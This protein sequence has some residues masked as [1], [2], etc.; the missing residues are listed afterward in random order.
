MSLIVYGSVENVLSSCRTVPRSVAEE[1]WGTVDNHLATARPNRFNGVVLAGGVHMDSM[2]GGIPLIRSPRT[3][4]QA[5]LDRRT[6]PPS[7]SSRSPGST[8]VRRRHRHRR[9]T[10]S[11]LDDHPRYPQGPAVGTVIGLED[12]SPLFR[13]YQQFGSFSLTLPSEISEAA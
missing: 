8:V 3:S 9:R 13:L 10:G 4:W 2:R 7:T 5:F 6:H 1:F 11:R 12:T